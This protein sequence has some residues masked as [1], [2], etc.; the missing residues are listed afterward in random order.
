MTPNEPNEGAGTVSEGEVADAGREPDD[1][2]ALES[3]D[4]EGEGNGDEG[5]ADS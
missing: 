2:G 1:A 4:Q 5:T 3:A